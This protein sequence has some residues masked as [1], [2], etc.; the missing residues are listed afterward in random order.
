MPIKFNI[1]TSGADTVLDLAQRLS[2]EV[3]VECANLRFYGI[4]NKFKITS[5]FN[6]TDKAESLRNPYYIFAYEIE[7]GA[8]D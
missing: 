7:I 4:D 5:E 2:K 6:R 3:E 8:D 1:I